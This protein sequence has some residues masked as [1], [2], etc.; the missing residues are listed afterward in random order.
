MTPPEIYWMNMKKLSNKLN[1]MKNINQELHHSLSH[2]NNNW[3][4]VKR[5]QKVLWN[6]TRLIKEKNIIM[7]TNN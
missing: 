7:N 5:V 3:I 2:S 1:K 4:K 6:Q